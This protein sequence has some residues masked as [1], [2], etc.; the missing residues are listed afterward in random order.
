[1]KDL[2]TIGRTQSENLVLFLFTL[3]M[4]AMGQVQLSAYSYPTV[5]VYEPLEIGAGNQNWQ[6]DQK[7][8][9]DI[10]IGN[11]EGLLLFNGSQWQLYKTPAASVV[12]SVRVSEDRIYSGGYMDM[13]YWTQAAN[14]QYSYT[15]LVETLQLKMQSD[16]QI[17]NIKM[18]ENGILYQSLNR[19]YFFDPEKNSLDIIDTPK[20]VN[21][22]F[23]FGKRTYFQ[24]FEKNLYIL[25]NREPIL[26]Y[27]YLSLPSSEILN[28]FSTDYGIVLF[29]KED[30]FYKL[31]DGG[32]KP[33]KI[34]NQS[35]LDLGDFFCAVQMRNGNIVLGSITRG[36]F[37]LDKKG[38][39]L[40]HQDQMAGLS[41]NTVL[42]I[43]EDR[44][45][46]LWLGLD[47]GINTV[48]LN[49][50]FSEF[51][52]KAGKL[53]TV[54]TAA[55]YREKLYVGTNQGLFCKKHNSPEDF[56]LV[57][58]TNGQV[59]ILKLINDEL[60]CGHNLGTY[61]IQGNKAKKISSELGTWKIEAVPGNEELLFQGNY[62]GFHILKKGFSGWEYSHQIGEF[63]HSARQFA[64]LGNRFYYYH[65]TLGFCR[66]EFNKGFKD[67]KNLT[68]ITPSKPFSQANLI[69]CG[70][71]IIFA[72]KE[73][74]FSMDNSED[75]LKR[76]DGLDLKLVNSEGL[77]GT[78]LKMDDKDF[79][80][81][82]K[83]HV[84]WF[85]VNEK[86]E[87]SLKDQLALD[88]SLYKSKTEF[89]NI[90][91]I[92]DDRYLLGMTNGYVIVDLRK[93]IYLN[94]TFDVEISSILLNSKDGLSIPID[95]T[96]EE[97]FISTENNFS[98]HFNIDEKL[99][100]QP[101]YYQYKLEGDEYEWNEWT[102][103]PSV[104]YYKLKAGPYSFKVR[105]KVSD[106]ISENEA[107]FTFWIKNPWYLSPYA[108]ISYFILFVVAIFTTNYLYRVVYSKRQKQLIDKNEKELE[109]LKLKSEQEL[110]QE[111]ND[112]LRTEIE[113]M[114]KELAVT[115]MS[116][117][118][119][120]EFL[121]E[122]R[123]NL[124]GI[125][126]NTKFKPE[127]MIRSINREIENEES[128]EMLKN[129]FENVDKDF[130]QKIYK[131]HPGLTPN[132]LKLCTYLRLNLNS[133]EIATLLNI[134]VRSM[135]T[136]RYRLR[137]KLGL[138]HDTNLVEYILGI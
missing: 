40:L 17:W 137:K 18:H 30:G 126:K 81:I 44:S 106:K 20:G 3:I 76:V 119:K 26:Y 52:D 114:N 42:T 36:Y 125:D 65:S 33:W 53:G 41:N 78:L 31:G 72:N 99:K 50:P 92:G 118:K 16:E 121:I 87:I 69:S 108:T 7:A 2:A 49:S 100:Y 82:N 54:Y 74:L 47:N 22:V 4:L 135:E 28:M 23:Q 90:A 46:N 134:S 34:A 94:Q 129:A 86:G 77:I 8:N 58:N 113:S 71:R 37:M 12:R 83:D 136:K 11:E 21:K 98:F 38:D 127:L 138:T 104:S 96:R 85:E 60:F 116:I 66:F 110:M 6:I 128:W 79:C 133:K 35:L 45:R 59:W 62:E 111:K 105:A 123:E 55:V 107:S 80:M 117:V 19:L 95:R 64:M 131:K 25:N 13:G 56:E 89:E 10:V 124:K 132:D 115:A 91:N 15:S 32:F 97:G 103:S 70:D 122:I 61:L 14:G 9:G 29:S 24:D 27:S 101:V 120:N 67:L 63:N 48:L 68:V 93:S 130:I 112:R 75:S 109:Y 5:A 73:G 1:M 43:F 57:E 39:L 102:E 84:Y 51:I 88:P